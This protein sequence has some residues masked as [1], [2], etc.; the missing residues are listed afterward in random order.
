[1]RNLEQGLADIRDLVCAQVMHVAAADHDVFCAA[2]QQPGGGLVEVV[3]AAQ[4]TGLGGV[5]QQP[6]DLRQEHLAQGGLQVGI[7]QIAAAAGAQHRVQN[8]GLGAGL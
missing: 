3:T 8:H 2:C 5:R 4:A 6:V 1:M 7:G